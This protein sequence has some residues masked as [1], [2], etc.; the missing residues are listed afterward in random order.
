[1]NAAAEQIS[2]GSGDDMLSA[3]TDTVQSTADSSNDAHEADRGVRADGLNSELANKWLRWQ[4]KICL[5]YT[6][7]AADE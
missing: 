2:P 4:C 7:D 5:L 3:S 1:M 6:S